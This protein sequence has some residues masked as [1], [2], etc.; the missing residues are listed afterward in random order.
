MR[1]IGVDVR[2]PE[3]DWD[4][5]QNCPFYGSLRVRGQIIE[6]V[7]SSSGMSNSIVVQREVTRYMKKY[8]RYEKRTRKYSAHLPSCIGDVSEG[9]RVR[10]MECRPLS[11]TV[12]FCVI[13]KEMVE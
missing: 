10:I 9:D 13:E 2:N 12:K 5:D 8:E 11:K 6:G 7:V 3:G 4:G 1:D